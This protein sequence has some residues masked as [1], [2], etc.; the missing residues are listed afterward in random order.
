MADAVAE[1][2]GI[3]SF[4]G[5]INRGRFWAL[6]LGVFASIVVIGIIAAIAV[7]G[8]AS[9]SGSSTSGDGPLPYVLLALLCIVYVTAIWISL[10]TQAKRWHDLDKSGWFVLL[11]I[12]PIIGFFVLIYLGVQTGTP[13]PNRFGP[14][15]V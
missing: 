1:T 9:M 4:T 13:G 12:I 8:L 3:F 5:R 6:V 2:S 14:A 11:N 10:A 15:P 7:P